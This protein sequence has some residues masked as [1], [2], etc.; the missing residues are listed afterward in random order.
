MRAMHSK[1]KVLCLFKSWLVLSLVA[2]LAVFPGK[3][4]RAYLNSAHHWGGGGGSV[5]FSL[6]PIPEASPEPGVK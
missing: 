6:L 1:L 4:I 3:L 2:R 5:H